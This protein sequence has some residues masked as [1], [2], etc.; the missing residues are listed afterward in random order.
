MSLYQLTGKPIYQGLLFILLSI[1]AT[2][3]ANPK[4]ADTIWVIGGLVY[5]FFILANAVLAFFTTNTWHYFFISL[6]VSLLY[7]V[8]IAIVVNI[9]TNVYRLKGTEESA[10]IFLVIIFH[11]LVLLLSIFL[12]WIL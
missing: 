11:P 8:V 6:G 5:C 10:M 1:M 2:L 12:K 4:K 9:F 3:I 7:L